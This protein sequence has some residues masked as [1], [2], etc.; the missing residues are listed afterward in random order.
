MLSNVIKN[1]TPLIFI[2][3]FY[4]TTSCATQPHT[5]TRTPITHAGKPGASH[6]SGALSAAEKAQL[7]KKYTLL[8][9]EIIE[10]V[11]ETEGGYCNHPNDRGG[12]TNFGICH[13]RYPHINKKNITKAEAKALYKRD[14]WDNHWYF[15][16]INDKKLLAKF[17][18]IAIHTGVG[19]AKRLL[20]R[21]LRCTGEQCHEHDPLTQSLV[22]KINQKDA[23]MLLAALKSETAGYYRMLIAKNEDQS[24]F[25]NGWLRRAYK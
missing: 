17:L 13:Q 10:T 9:E 7:E 25:L 2:S 21:A 19:N 3:I 4:L 6:G 12:E 20:L 11:F 1:R 14:Y 16:K 24:V 22:Q 18:D 15:K 5:A 23:T 8:F